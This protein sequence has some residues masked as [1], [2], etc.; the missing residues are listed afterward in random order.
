MTAGTAKLATQKRYEL[1]ARVLRENI[2]SGRLP[3]GLVLTEGPIADVMGSSRAPVQAAL[4][5]LEDEGLVHRFAGRG[6]LVGRPGAVAAP[7]RR[8][9]RKLNLKIAG[10]IGDALET[11]GA[12]E[13]FYDQVEEEVAGCL[14]FGQFRII[15][16]ELAAH[17]GVGRTVVRELLSRL[18]ERGLIRKNRSSHWTV[19]PLTAR[20]VREKFE[21]RALLEPEAL[22]LAAPLLDYRVIEEIARQVQASELKD[23][24]RL[25]GLLFDHCLAL[26]PN[27]ELVE[28]IRQARFLVVAADRAL[29]ILGPQ[30][31][32][33]A[34]E[35]YRSIFGLLARHR[36]NTA[37]E[38][39]RGH[40]RLMAR[41]NLARLKIVAVL[42]RPATL[43]PYLTETENV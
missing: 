41:K 17:L 6:V 1:I 28:V 29:S 2:A 3:A 43:A 34:L 23:P 32:Q 12:W 24:D 5:L 15:E 38:F 35:E 42:G 18:S 40:L 27:R 9:I 4:K 16:T 21:L 31:D 22:R 20:S 10:E 39:L 30:Q 11:R 14:I 7:L 36:I 13:A 26:A 8:D 37:A 33:L 25:Q 19:G